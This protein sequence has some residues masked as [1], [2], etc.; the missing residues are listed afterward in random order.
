MILSMRKNT[1]STSLKKIIIPKSVLHSVQK[2]L[3]AYYNRQLAYCV[4]CRSLAN[5]YWWS[6]KNIAK[7]IEI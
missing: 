2:T 4:A 6:K 3:T 1:R 7:W 5:Y